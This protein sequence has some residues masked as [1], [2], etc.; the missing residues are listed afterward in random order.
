MSWTEGDFVALGGHKYGHIVD[1]KPGRVCIDFWWPEWAPRRKHVMEWVNDDSN[2]TEPIYDR[3]DRDPHMWE[4]KW[5]VA[6]YLGNPDE[7][8]VAIPEDS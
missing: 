4:E 7:G 3:G 6:D 8:W 1:T 5:W 2:L